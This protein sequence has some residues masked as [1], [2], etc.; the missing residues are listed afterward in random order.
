MHSRSESLGFM[1]EE[2]RIFGRSLT[3]RSRET[4]FRAYQALWRARMLNLISWQRRG[5]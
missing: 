1:V 5:K 2:F 4:S 3:F